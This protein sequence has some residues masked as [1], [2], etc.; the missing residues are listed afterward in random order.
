MPKNYRL[1][2]LNQCVQ[3]TGTFAPWNTRPDA[4]YC[5]LKCSGAAKRARVSFK[6]TVCDKPFERQLCQAKLNTTAFCSRA[7]KGVVKRQ[8]LL[9]VGAPW[10][11]GGGMTNTGY[12]QISVDSKRYLDHRYKMQEHLGRPLT[13]TEAVHHIDGNKLN[14]DIS[15]LQVMTYREHQLLHWK[16]KRETGSWR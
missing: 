2:K 8:E 12:W 14:N 15:N 1:G 9:G 11:K 4:Q 13:S 10:Y 5:S 6:C 7:C 16:Q 3:C